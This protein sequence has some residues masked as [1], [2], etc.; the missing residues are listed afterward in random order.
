MISERAQV[1][2]RVCLSLV[3]VCQI[4]NEAQRITSTDRYTQL[5]IKKEA[6]DLQTK[7]CALVRS[8]VRLFSES[9]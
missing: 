3:F 7:A 6:D 5:Q 8:A 2:V 1:C 9:L 4:C